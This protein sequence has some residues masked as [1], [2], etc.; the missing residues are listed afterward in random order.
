MQRDRVQ[1]LQRIVD[2]ESTKP[3]HVPNTYVQSYTKQASDY[4][5]RV[6]NSNARRL[7]SLQ[8]VQVRPPAAQGASQSSLA[9][10]SVE[11]RA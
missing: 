3:L 5:R 10:R 9:L 11:A 4:S 1:W 8:K 6:A 7:K 2:E